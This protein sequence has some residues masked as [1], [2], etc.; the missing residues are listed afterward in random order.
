MQTS[1]KNEFEQR[2]SA[3]MKK[4]IESDPRLRAERRKRRLSIAFSMAGSLVT[5]AVVT[6]LIKSFLL[7]IHGPQG[8]AQ[9]VAPVLHGQ[10]RESLAVQLLGADPLSTEIAAFLRPMLPAATDPV[11]RN[12]VSLGDTLTLSVEAEQSPEI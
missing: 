4:H 3:L 12:A 6:L 5:I 9:M 2:R 11:A 7:A 10:D 8:Y 1:Q